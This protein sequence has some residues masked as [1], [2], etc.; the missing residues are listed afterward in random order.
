MENRRTAGGAD[1]VRMP[2]WGHRIW[3]IYQFGFGEER[4][5]GGREKL[6]G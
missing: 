5:G 4:N 2:V 3:K 1:E 6:Y